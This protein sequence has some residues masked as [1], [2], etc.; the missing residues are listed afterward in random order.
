MFYYIVSSCTILIFSKSLITKSL[1]YAII[2]P[3][4]EFINQAQIFAAR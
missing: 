2:T 3:I 1:G 4:E